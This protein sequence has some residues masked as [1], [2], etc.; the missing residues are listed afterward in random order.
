[1][2]VG[3][4]GAGAV[5]DGGPVQRAAAAGVVAHVPA[6]RADPSD[7]GRATTETVALRAGG[8]ARHEAIA[9]VAAGASG[10]ARAFVLELLGTVEA[11]AAVVLD[12]GCAGQGRGL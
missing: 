4:V 7:I 11:G 10:R 9:E 12:L 2:G 1:Q 5:G 8:G 6:D 3:G